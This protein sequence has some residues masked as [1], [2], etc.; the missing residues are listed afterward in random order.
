[1][2]FLILSTPQSY[3]SK[4]H[5]QR[6]AEILVAGSHEIRIFTPGQRNSF[7]MFFLIL[8]DTLRTATLRENILTDSIG[9]ATVAFLLGRPFTL[10][11]T[12]F[13]PRRHRRW[14][15]WT[16]L[17]RVILRRAK[18]LITFNSSARNG[19]IHLGLR[20]NAVQLLAQ[21]TTA[22]P[23][24]ATPGSD[25]EHLPQVLVTSFLPGQIQCAAA[26]FRALAVVLEAV[27]NVHL[28]ATCDADDLDPLEHR[29]AAMG[30][31]A[32]VRLRRNE[33]ADAPPPRAIALVFCGKGDA[34]HAAFAADALGYG[35]SIAAVTHPHLSDWLKEEETALLVAPGNET[36]LADAIIRLLRTPALREQLA[37]NAAAR[38]R[39]RH[40]PEDFLNALCGPQH[41]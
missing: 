12:D 16:L 36:G 10:L 40:R 20:R 26:V 41:E 37:R 32:H 19:V 38:A 35:M 1:M 28:D 33:E 31:E 14:P 24:A 17:L 23:R 9:A 8:T 39:D 29:L 13:D 5:L 7:V 3:F 18:P 21:P 34:P 4:Q 11:L 15:L 2:K 25:E 27:P 22:S 6:I 30:L